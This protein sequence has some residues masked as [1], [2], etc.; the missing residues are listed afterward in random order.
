MNGARAAALNFILSHIEFGG[1]VLDIGAGDS[2]LAHMLT[3]RQCK[4]LAIDTN[5]ERLR[6]A[7]EKANRSYEICVKDARYIWNPGEYDF[8]LSVYAIQHMIPYEPLIWVKI[9]EALKLGGKFLIVG[10]YQVDA[11]QYEPRE[12]PLIGANEQTIGTLAMLT[13]FAIEHF[14][15]Y[16]YRDGDNDMER[17]VDGPCN[18]F[19]AEL[20]AV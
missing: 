1:K 4:V 11:P 18:A 2:P 13:G 17:V 12:D 10:R 5:A 20:E 14:W 8:V 6:E 15:H 7:W 16:M 19:G 9:R 3:K